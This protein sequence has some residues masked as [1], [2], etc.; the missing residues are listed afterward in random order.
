V[1]LAAKDDDPLLATWQHG[2]GRSAV[3]TTDAGAQLGRPWLGWPG[4]TALYGQLVRDIVRSPERSDARVHVSLRGG[5][6]VVRVEAV[7]EQG[8]YR[9]Y[10][11]LAATVAAPGGDPV[12]V[13]LAQT[14]AGRYE[15]TFD[16]NAPGPYLV[17]VREGEQG[18]VGSAGLVRAAGDELRGEGTDHAKLAQI[19]AL[20]GG[21]VRAD[22]AQ[23]FR[24]RPPPSWAHR[25]TWPYLLA[26][27]L[28]LLLASVAMRRLVLPSGLFA[29][30]VPWR[31]RAPAR[32]RTSADATLPQPTAAHTTTAAPEI[33]RAREATSEDAP[34]APSAS[35]P[36]DDTPGDPP[37]SAP[38]QPSS[39]AETLLARKRSRR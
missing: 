16:A 32:A 33:T 15:G 13:T 4:Y 3:L 21:T 10:L 34:A 30:L 26:A 25:Q 19:A 20:T 1:L 23:V 2:I 35:P 39:L 36:T 12:Q 27:A 7:D 9:N 37:P 5:T 31:K 11:D 38:A 14:G 28:A 18:M 6:G 24:E 8:R 22:L 29:R 17:T